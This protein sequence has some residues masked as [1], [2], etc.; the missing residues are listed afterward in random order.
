MSNRIFVFSCCFSQFV[1][2][3]HTNAIAHE[4]MCRCQQ[5]KERELSIRRVKNWWLTVY[6]KMLCCIIRF[7]SFY[8]CNTR[9][10]PWTLSFRFSALLRLNLEIFFNEFVSEISSNL[11]HKIRFRLTLTSMLR[12]IQTKNSIGVRMHSVSVQFSCSDAFATNTY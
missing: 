9:H 10:V 8:F 1:C 3:T 12:R 11:E 7:Y 2:A 4:Y 6:R 5:K